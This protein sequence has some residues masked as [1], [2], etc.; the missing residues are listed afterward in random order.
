MTFQDEV[1]KEHA[2]VER[3]KKQIEELAEGCYLKTELQKILGEKKSF[4][5]SLINK[6]LL[7]K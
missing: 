2:I 5:H 6:D 4:D 3:L 7:D 1:I